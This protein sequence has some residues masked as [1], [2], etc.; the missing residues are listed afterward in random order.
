[1]AINTRGTMR[2]VAPTKGITTASIISW[3]LQNGRSEQARGVAVGVAREVV[4]GEGLDGG[5]VVEW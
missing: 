1:M 5:S 2:K 3:S 4:L